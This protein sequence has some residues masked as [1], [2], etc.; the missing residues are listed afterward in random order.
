MKTDVRALV[1]TVVR[2]M[3]G[4]PT[5][6]APVDLRERVP[7]WPREIPFP[8]APVGVSNRHVH[9]R[10]ATV[11]VLFGPGYKMTPHRDLRQPGQWASKETVTV[12][13]PGGRSI[14][15]L[16]MVGPCRD[17]D[18]VEL[19]VTDC[20]TLGIPVP[21]LR[22]SG[23]LEG[24][25]SV[26]VTGPRGC[27]TLPRGVILAGRHLHIH[28]EEAAPLGLR[29]RDVIRVRVRGPRGATLEN[30]IARVGEG[31]RLELHLDTDEANAVGV[32]TNDLVE[33]LR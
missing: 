8:F 19:A 13:G 16:R 26:V 10:Q 31:H 33:I 24:T 3:C 25:G 1:E 9:L 20:V 18:Q 29:D 12:V 32:K 23:D 27:A 21:P 5:A 28:P 2:E 11:E 22:Q 15:G 7:G 30:V 14:A 17:Y 4:A 6:S